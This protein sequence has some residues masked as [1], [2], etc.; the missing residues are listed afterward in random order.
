MSLWS[1]FPTPFRVF[2]AAGKVE[3]RNGSC[4]TFTVSA[5]DDI[6]R[7]ADFLGLLFDERFPV[8]DDEIEY[9]T[10][11]VNDRGTLEQFR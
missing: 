4:F 9:G 6:K 8:V 1:S 7:S 2:D 11:S 3:T 10:S 5:N